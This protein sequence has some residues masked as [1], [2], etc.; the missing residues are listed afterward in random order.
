MI[1]AQNL[2]GAAY[3]LIDE[4]V[5]SG[6]TYQYVLEVVGTTGSSLWSDSTQVVVPYSV[7]LPSIHW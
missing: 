4:P 3:E 2:E 7:F 1:P 5:E 6:A